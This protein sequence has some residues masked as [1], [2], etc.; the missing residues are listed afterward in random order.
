LPVIAL[1]PDTD[2]TPSL[3]FVAIVKFELKPAAGTYDTPASSALTL[4]I[5]PDAV[6]TP[7]PALY[8]DVTA[9]DVAVV[10][11]PAAGFDRVNVAVT[12]ALSTSET[13]IGVKPRVEPST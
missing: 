10:R 13:T 1:L 6:H 5:A 12:L 11:A 4:A 7:V 9:P 8:V 3:T 2:R